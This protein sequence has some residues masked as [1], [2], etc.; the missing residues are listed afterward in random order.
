MRQIKF[1]A[2][3]TELK[4]MVIPPSGFRGICFAKPDKIIRDNWDKLIWMQF[5]GLLDKNKKEIYEGDICKWKFLEDGDAISEVYYFG[6]AFGL[7][8]QMLNTMAK[9]SIEIIGNIYENPELLK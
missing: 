7:H 2:W 1:R 8:G 6:A 4:E 3:E 5:T 9:D